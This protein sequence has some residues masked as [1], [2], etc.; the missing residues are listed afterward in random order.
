MKPKKEEIE[1]G[2][3]KGR[4]EKRESVILNMLKKKMDISTIVECTGVSKEHIIQLQKS[5]S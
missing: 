4:E 5:L 1:K 2:K 3:E